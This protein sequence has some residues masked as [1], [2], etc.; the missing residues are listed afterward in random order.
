MAKREWQFDLDGVTYGVRMQHSMLV[1]DPRVWVD[2]QPA[3]LEPQVPFALTDWT[4]D[5][6]FEI[7]E[8]RACLSIR[9]NGLWYSYRLVID[10]LDAATGQPARTS[11]ATPIR[12]PLEGLATNYPRFAAGSCLTVLVAF[13]AVGIAFFIYSSRYGV[14]DT[15]VTLAELHLVPDGTWVDVVDLDCD[16]MI[17]GRLVAKRLAD[18]SM[19]V[20]RGPCLGHSGVYRR[21]PE[22]YARQVRE[23]LDLRDDLVLRRLSIIPGP[24]NDRV[25]AWVCLTFASLFGLLAWASSRAILARRR[26]AWSTPADF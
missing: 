13:F 17:E 3:A 19:L 15:E 1:D 26:K 12:W 9:Q 22:A 11:P 18:G 10:G 5:Y 7:G 21:A 14:T 2:G 23:E 20:I 8:R 24:A 25:G 6:L 16:A 4:N